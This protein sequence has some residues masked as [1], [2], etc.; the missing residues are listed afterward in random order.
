VDA[1]SAKHAGSAQSTSTIQIHRSNKTMEELGKLI[2][3]MEQE[4][5]RNSNTDSHMVEGSE[6]TTYESHLGDGDEIFLSANTEEL[7]S[8]AE[9]I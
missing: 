3:D 4:L 7:S 9:L 8:H 2:Q 1:L 6:P 5:N